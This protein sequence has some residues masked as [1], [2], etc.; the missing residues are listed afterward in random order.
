MKIYLNFRENK[1]YFSGSQKQKKLWRERFNCIFYLR[2]LI[3]NNE[4]FVLDHT[5]LQL[6]QMIFCQK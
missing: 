2:C 6:L 5:F 1:F 3:D 4:I